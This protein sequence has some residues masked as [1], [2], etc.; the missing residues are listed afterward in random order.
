MFLRFEDQFFEGTQFLDQKLDEIQSKADAIW[1]IIGVIIIS[2]VYFSKIFLIFI[3]D[4]LS[5]ILNLQYQIAFDKF[6][7]NL[8]SFVTRKFY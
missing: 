5:G 6:Q 7:N 4:A 2:G 8:N 1:I 3:F